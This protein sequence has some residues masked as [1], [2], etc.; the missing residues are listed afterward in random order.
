M[1]I[2]K[3][4][5][6]EFLDSDRVI[7]NPSV[8]KEYSSDMTETEEGRV[9]LVVKI[10]E[11]NELE[12]VVKYAND[13]KI[14]VVPAVARTNLGGLCIPKDGGIILDLCGMNK[15]RGVDP[16]AM[17][18][19]IEPGVTFQ[20]LH[21][22]LDKNYPDLAFGYPLSPPTSSVLANCILD[23][24]SNLSLKYGSMAEW[25]TGMEVLLPDGT[26][27]KTGSSAVVSQWFGKPPLS[28][29]GGIFVSSQGTL[30]IVT[31]IGVTLWPKPKCKNRFFILTYDLRKSMKLVI[32]LAREG[33][34]DDLAALSWTTGK[35]L[36][37]IYKPEKAPDDPSFFVYIDVSAN[38]KEELNF[39][40]K[41]IEKISREIDNKGGDFTEL[42]PIEDI[43]RINQ[44]FSKFSTFPTRLDFLLDHE[45]GGLTWV[46]T[47]GPLANFESA[48][49]SVDDILKEYDREPIIVSRPMKGG[50]FGVLRFISIFNKK[51]KNEINEIRKLNKKIFESI[52]P[53]GFVMYKTPS[54][55]IRE[56]NDRVDPG[57]KKLFLSLKKL[58]DPNN[59]MN[60]DKLNWK[61]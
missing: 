47:Y 60:P 45:Y 38:T 14:P 7:D 56:L 18:A 10:K 35:M 1:V 11:K 50:H 6:I 25:I 57:F 31:K 27:V 8:L 54:W 49:L 32:T 29:L 42:L 39:K 21:D 30:G 4:K 36:F 58:I 17:V 2:D 12:K 26:I 13:N 61:C 40:K 37:D 28:D 51:D 52:L 24:L 53:F 48:I 16:D 41:R 55:A 22:Y 23:G 9:D 5:L 33:V 15:I 3:N 43:V 59:I 20:D 44:K 19:V 46:G 34:V